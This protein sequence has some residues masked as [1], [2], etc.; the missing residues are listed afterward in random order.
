MLCT[1]TLQYPSVSVGS[2][3]SNNKLAYKC[4]VDLF[5]KTN[6][7]LWDMGEGEGEGEVEQSAVT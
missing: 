4:F 3:V 2:I 1:H 5:F 6:R 7:C